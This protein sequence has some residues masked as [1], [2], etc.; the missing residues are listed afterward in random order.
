MS[1]MMNYL[2]TTLLN[3]TLRGIATPVVTQPYVALFTVAPN[4]S[5]LGTEVS[6]NGY[7]R[8]PIS[9]S[10]P[11]MDVGVKNSSD[12]VFPQATAS[13]GNIVAIGIFDSLNGNM[14]YYATLSTAK[15]VNAADVFRILA[16][17]VTVSLD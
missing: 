5:A 9:F 16:N 1:S 4:E 10:A 14:M 13:W 7:A 6:G 2:E 12:V 11:V 3:H 8:Q 17:G 15:T